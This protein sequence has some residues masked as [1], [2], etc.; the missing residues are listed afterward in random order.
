[1]MLKQ[2]SIVRAFGVSFIPRILFLTKFSL[3]G[4]LPGNV[5]TLITYYFS[6]VVLLTFGILHF[7]SLPCLIIGCSLLFTESAACLIQTSFVTKQLLGG[8]NSL[9]DQNL[10]RIIK[11]YGVVTI[12]TLLAM[13]IA[14]NEKKRYKNI[15]LL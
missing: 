2:D 1:M 10:F 12:V 7:Q 13:L 8:T 9:L 5:Q 11:E 15:Q 3:D 14:C 4:M 6:F